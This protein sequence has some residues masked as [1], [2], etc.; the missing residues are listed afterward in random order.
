MPVVAAVLIEP[1]NEPKKILRVTLLLGM[2]L[3]HGTRV[4][5]DQEPA[6]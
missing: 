6:G 3:V 1:E 2:Q 4:I 5:V